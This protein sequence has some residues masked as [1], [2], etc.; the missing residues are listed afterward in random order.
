[1]GFTHIKDMTS[2]SGIGDWQTIGNEFAVRQLQGAVE[3]G[4]VSHAYLFTGPDRVGKRTLGMDLA[5]ALC[6]SRATSNGSHVAVPCGEC[7]AC[8]RV[9]RLAHPDVRLINVTTPTSKD[10]DPDAAAKRVSIS[11]DL[12]N[13]VQSES[14][15]EPYESNH[16]VFLIDGA[17]H[18]Y[19][20]AA[21]ALLKTLEEP[22]PSVR[23]LLTAPSQTQLPST[24]V[25]RCHVINLRPVPIDT[26]ALA[27]VSRFSATEADARDLAALSGGNPGWA[28]AALSDPS[29]VDNA[30]ESASRILTTLASG[31]EQ[32]FNYAMDIGTKFRRDRPSIVNE[33]T[34][35]TEVVRDIA[36]VKHGL[37]EKTPATYDRQQLETIAGRMSDGDIGLALATIEETRD[38]VNANTLPQLAIE[39][40]MLELPDLSG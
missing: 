7:S 27:L 36:L 23:L 3:R 29:M 5:R 11:I 26:I 8:D 9:G 4:R 28:I 40:M 25:S 24:I 20:E 2:D 17:H 34:R 39:V 16:R 37:G 32:R 31:L 10:A 18:M 35:W 12:I 6:C 14:I 22:P 15:L 13:D 30:R 19:I 38:A 21:N 1:M 33:M